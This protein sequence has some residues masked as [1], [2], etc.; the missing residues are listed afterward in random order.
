MRRVLI[1]LILI[2]NT[3]VFAQNKEYKKLSNLLNT[4]KYDKC[5]KLSKKI[6]SKKPQEIK[7]LYYCSKANF[8]L[9]KKDSSS[10]SLKQS[11]KYMWKLVKIDKKHQYISLYS[12]HNKQLKIASEKYA[13]QLFYKNK[14]NSKVYFDY[15]AKIYNDTLSQYYEFYP[16]LK[17]PTD[18][19][20]GLNTAE[21]SVNKIDKNGKKQ[22]FW[23][24]KYKSGVVAYEVYFKDDKP[25][26]THKRYHSNGKLMAILVF[27][28]SSEWSD[29]QLFDENASLIAKGKYK[30]K[31]KHGLWTLYKD[32][33]IVSKINY[34]DGKKHG[35]AE[36][37]YADNGKKSEEKH[38]NHDIENGVWR[39]YYHNGQVRLET[40][41]ENGKRNGIYL[42]YH[43]NGRLNVKGS[44][45]N[46]IMDGAW[47]YYDK[48]GKQ[49]DL[50]N[51]VDGKA[52][53]QEEMN[54]K[55]IEILKKLEENK[56]RFI[57]PA[58]Y[59]KNPQEYFKKVKEQGDMGD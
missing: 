4:K 10:N 38:W 56:G 43:D 8:E 34:L 49:I 16:D 25:V 48:S 36:T 6:I 19:K 30:N 58:K 27:D 23:T 5:I 39:Q 26:G 57:D 31:Q 3:A 42:M 41:I 12:E 28:D 13:E 24:K 20:I 33:S 54:K 35:L 51:Y 21:T 37:F 7:P 1:L 40:K 29:A 11:L 18:N 32:T 44:F 59:I 17:K 22:G 2:V 9:F 46:D 50:I 14:N 53:K 15:I 55:Q 45:K 47:I 52:D